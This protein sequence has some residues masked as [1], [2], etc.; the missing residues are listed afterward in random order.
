MQKEMFRAGLI[1]EMMDEG[2]HRWNR[3]P[4]TPTPEI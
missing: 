4:P 1:Q 3:K 2:I